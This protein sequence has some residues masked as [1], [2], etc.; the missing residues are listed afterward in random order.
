MTALRITSRVS[1]GDVLAAAVSVALPLLG[2]APVASQERQEAVRTA[3]MP[4]SAIAR[5][6]ARQSAT[7]SHYG[8]RDEASGF[9]AS[10]FDGPVFSGAGDG[11]IHASRVC[12]WRLSQ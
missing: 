8:P 6:A 10:D 2:V 11:N 12:D 5:K 9:A 1:V 3:S 7:R 4:G